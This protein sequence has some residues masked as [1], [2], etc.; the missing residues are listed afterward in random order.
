MPKIINSYAGES[1]L[2]EAIKGF[3][4]SFGGNTAAQEF[5]R[6]KAFGL[7]RENKSYQT[8]QDWERNNPGGFDPNNGEL[9]AAIVG[10][11]QPKE[12]F[13]AQRG[14]AAT[15]YGAG[16][17]RA[18]NAYM[19]A[20]GNYGSTVAGTNQAEAN[21]RGIEDR[22]TQRMFDIER[23]KFDNTF[24]QAVDPETKQ[25]V[26][27]PRTQASGRVSG[28]QAKLDQAKAI[29][30]G[31]TQRLF[32]AERYKTDNTPELVQTPDGPR[33]ERRSAA[34]GMPPVLDHS[35]AQGTI[36]QQDTPALTPDQR[37]TAGG[38]TPKNPANA[39][40]YKRDDGSYGNT[41]DMKTDAQTG[42]PI[43]GPAMKLEGA[44]TEGLS[45][46]HQVDQKLLAARNAKDI[47]VSSIERLQ[48]VLA[49]PNADQS[50]G[51]LGAVA[52]GFNDLRAQA[53]ATARLFGGQLRDQAFT[54]PENKA[55]VD[56]VMASVFT[57]DRMA[58]AQARGIDANIIRSQVQ[59]LAFMIAQTQNPDGRV[60][61]DDIHRAAETVGGL[62]MDPKTAVP[63]LDDL[64]NRLVAAHDI[65]ERNTRQ[66]YPGVKP[67][68]GAPA[69]AAPS[70]TPTAPPAAAPSIRIDVN[71]NIIP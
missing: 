64:K 15:R 5:A 17:E 9:R 4:G 46:N 28:E 22:R 11:P 60:A 29:E 33:I 49:Q 57:P 47:A 21:K 69:A 37:A 71:G 48:K 34:F 68:P 50:M 24:E 42:Q 45:G 23:Y 2:S 51:Y 62:I 7:S 26:L 12:F 65:R 10:L 40:V 53:E 70:A 16:D 41:V 55:T 14:I 35:K 52:R 61:K 8:A 44:N 59:D 38:Y 54:S 43:T 58:L 56:T 32:D 67:V 13:E 19:G 25:V 36:L 39:W 31:R 20:G 1:P 6:Q 27:V 18:T 66:M 30:E 63:V 3:A